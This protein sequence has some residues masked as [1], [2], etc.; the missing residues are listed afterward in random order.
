MHIL[1]TAQ[2]GFVQV[3]VISYGNLQVLLELSIRVFASTRLWASAA[4]QRRTNTRLELSLLH[5]AHLLRNK[6]AGR[7]P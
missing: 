3:V 4:P 6:R 1:I 2:P 5:R 7:L